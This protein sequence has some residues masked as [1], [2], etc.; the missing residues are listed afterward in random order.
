MAPDPEQAPCKGDLPRLAARIV[1]AYYRKDYDTVLGHLASDCL[2]IGAGSDITWGLRDLAK[3]MSD[4]SE[5]PSF[6]VRDARFHVV[7][8]GSPSEAV[9]AGFY[10][11]YSDADHQMLSSERQRITINC[12]H[13]GGAWKAHLVHTS[14]E[15]GPLDG[16]IP[17]PVR[18]S[19]QTYRYVQDILRASRIRDEGYEESIALPVEGGTAFISP[20]RIV[21]AGAC[22]K[23][24]VIH[25]VDRTITVKLLL[26]NVFELLPRQFARVHR[27][28]VVNRGHI[29]ALSGCEVTMSNGDRI[30]IP[31]RRR[32]EVELELSRRTA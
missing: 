27:S 5:M 8:A 23:R 19:R 21:Y 12:R 4:A 6:L 25:L 24:T 11:I 7:E 18:V 1:T 13:Q 28:Y 26:A 16:D 2:F 30:P 22:A 17:F 15:W 31:K 29:T 20:S 3:A 10:T 32:L 9:I 14:N